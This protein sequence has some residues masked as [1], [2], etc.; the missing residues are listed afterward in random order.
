MILFN[1]L[2]TVSIKKL[3]YS[4]KALQFL[5]YN[6]LELK[7]RCFRQYSMTVNSKTA[8]PL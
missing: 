8:D 3:Q 1:T 7:P 4:V 5:K 2:Y 6:C